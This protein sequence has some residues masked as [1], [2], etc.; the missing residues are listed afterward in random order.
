M[1][2]FN[3]VLILLIIGNFISLFNT[4]KL[5]TLNCGLFS[6]SGKSPVNWDK[7]KIL[8]VINLERGKHSCGLSINKDVVIGH[9]NDTDENN[10]KNNTSEFPNFAASYHFS[11]PENSI[12]NTVIGH[13]RK[14]TVGAHSVNNAHPFKFDKKGDIIEN[15][16]NKE[17]NFIGA[18][19]GS[20]KN[21]KDLANSYHINLSKH[22]ID[23]KVLIAGV[24]KKQ[25]K[26]LNDYQGAAA[27]TITDVNDPNSIWVYRG[28]SK[29]HE[30]AKNLTKERPLYYVTTD[31]E[32][33]Y[34]SSIEDSLRII[35]EP[36]WGEVKELPANELT[37][38]KNGKIQ[39]SKTLKVKRAIQKTFT[40]T[41][42]FTHKPT[43][44]LPKDSK[45]IRFRDC[46]SPTHSGAIL[47]L[48]YKNR[49]YFQKGRYYYNNVLVDG[50][51]YIDEN[52]GEIISK[53]EFEKFYED[54]DLG[55]F[56]F[57]NGTRVANQEAME[58]VR[59]DLEKEFSYNHDRKEFKLPGNES[60]FKSK[61]LEIVS[62]Y[63][64]ESELIDINFEIKENISSFGSTRGSRN[65]NINY[66]TYYNGIYTPLFA[67]KAKF[68]FR[69]GDLLSIEEEYNPYLSTEAEPE[70]KNTSKKEEDIQ[71]S[72]PLITGEDKYT[73]GFFSKMPE[74]QQVEFLTEYP[75]VLSN[76][77]WHSI[78]SED[79][80]NMS[81]DLFDLVFKSHPDPEGV[82]QGKY[83]PI[84][85]FDFS[86][87]M[88]K[89][90]KGNLLKNYLEEAELYIDEINDNFNVSII[91]TKNFYLPNI[92]KAIKELNAL[93][94]NVQE[95]S[96]SEAVKLRGYLN[97]VARPRDQIRAFVNKGT[98]SLRTIK[99]LNVQ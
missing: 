80:N 76:L 46:M 82:L 9:A 20:L 72:L 5:D 39:S 60:L 43:I 48:Q 11:Y 86:E 17:A 99:T 75:S 35:Q 58:N 61:F 25:L 16:S 4:P 70:L 50:K 59:K 53:E 97:K 26:I 10:D 65:K 69:T 12:T 24:V 88:S 81:E 13:T 28:E 34:F 2:L 91:D 29:S 96:P 18:H 44:V 30:N 98:K 31:D 8:G 93:I 87:E 66:V 56:F 45:M 92:E 36:T 49:V 3:L 55:E 95:V 14:A 73:W 84:E 74:D 51:K 33:V 15:T 62:K 41:I 22:D 19:N 90:F 52:T 83:E 85:E 7:L 27:L 63:L 40:S 71:T 64:A 78:S 94:P 57:F 54:K 67:R 77:D 89:E 21:W 68:K 1:N 38:F 42:G 37:Y 79:W 6:Y 23:S 32:G 47:N